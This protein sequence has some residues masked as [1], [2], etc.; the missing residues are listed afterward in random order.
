MTLWD[1][2]IKLS[3]LTTAYQART[4]GARFHGG[5]RIF[6]AR[7]SIDQVVAQAGYGP[8]PIG[9]SQLSACR[10]TAVWLDPSGRF[11]S[12]LA[13]HDLFRRIFRYRC[14]CFTIFCIIRLIPLRSVIWSHSCPV[15][16]MS[17]DPIL[18]L[19]G[20]SC[21]P[22][23]TN[24]LCACID[25]GHRRIREGASGENCRDKDCSHDITP[26]SPCHDLDDLS[27]KPFIPPLGILAAKFTQS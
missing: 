5:A 1:T 24:N 15:L 20:R 7:V 27:L 11:Q 17:C 2:P 10:H 6:I 19:C 9:I 23:R 26:S 21:P 25:A 16:W 14:C 13:G 4:D 22:V 18:V 3:L 12:A 8:R